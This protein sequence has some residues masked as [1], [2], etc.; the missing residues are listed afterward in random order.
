VAPNYLDLEGPA[1]IVCI[2]LAIFAGMVAA[3]GSIIA[4]EK[5]LA[6]EAFGYLGV[7]LVFLVPAAA[8]FAW[9]S[10]DDPG[11]PWVGI[12]KVAIL[13]LTAVG[14]GMALYGLSL[15]L[16][17]APSPSKADRAPRTRRNALQTI[18]ATAIGLTGLASSV[19][20]LVSALKG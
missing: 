3:V 13:C 4:L 14:G 6:H 11:S 7:S 12:A 5:M 9:L 8:L 19:V 1:R 17:A 18:N 20:G 10:V 15:F 16:D 2:V